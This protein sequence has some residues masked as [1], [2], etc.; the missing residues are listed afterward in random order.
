MRQDEQRLYDRVR[1]RRRLSFLGDRRLV[2]KVVKLDEEVSYED[3]AW[4]PG[5]F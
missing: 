5:K 2:G 1:R 3:G 4:V